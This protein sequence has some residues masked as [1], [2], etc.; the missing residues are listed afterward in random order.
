MLKRPL[1]LMPESLATGWDILV[2]YA[3]EQWSLPEVH[4]HLQERL[5]DQ[6]NESEW[7]EPLDSVLRAEDNIDA[8]LAALDAFRNKWAPDGPSGLCEVATITN[9]HKKVEEELLD[10][11]TQLK[12]RRCINGQL[13]TLDEVLDPFGSSRGVRDWGDPLCIWRWRC[14]DCR[15]GSTGDGV[16]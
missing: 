10:L 15:D 13:C 9:E 7:N 6:Y 3:T 1:P 11:L 5:G 4:T 16:G 8:A 12:D 2:Q 14:G